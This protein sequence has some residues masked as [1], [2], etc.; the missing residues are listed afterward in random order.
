MFR[1]ALSQMKPI[2][3]F[4]AGLPLVLIFIRIYGVPITYDEAFTY[5]QYVIKH[6]PFHLNVANNHILNSILIMMTTVF[7]SYSEV[8]IR[9]PNFLMLVAAVLLTVKYTRARGSIHFGLVLSLLFSSY[10]IVEFYGLARGYTM[11]LCLNLMA[12]YK[13]PYENKQDLK[14][15]NILFFLAVLSSL[16]SLFLYLGFLTLVLLN[17]IKSGK[18][19]D[20]WYRKFGVWNFVAILLFYYW[21]QKIT[22]ATDPLYKADT[23]W[24]GLS[25]FFTSLYSS[26]YVL[27][28]WLVVFPVGM[29]YTIYRDRGK[30]VFIFLLLCL[31]VGYS[32]LP[33]LIIENKGFI[34]GRSWIP[35]FPL[36]ILPVMEL[37]LRGKWATRRGS[38]ILSSLLGA[39]IIFSSFYPYSSRNLR[40]FWQDN[41]M[42]HDVLMEEGCERKQV[43]HLDFYKKKYNLTPKPCPPSGG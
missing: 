41:T 40:S 19:L 6:R 13:Y 27:G 34:I 38:Y 4:I 7:K 16:S 32:A 24:E 8:L 1:S 21:G 28:V 37:V 9:L 25:I 39:C 11:S 23:V 26:R 31:S 15:G 3:Y 14:H 35:Y 22:Q 33:S 20:S 36:F 17:F 18:K 29:A 43:P 12:L 5:N 42:D 2:D 10:F 30:G